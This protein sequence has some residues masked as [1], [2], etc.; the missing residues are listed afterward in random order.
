MI[1]EG[2]IVEEQDE[3][4]ST[5]TTTTMTRK[6]D[7][8]AEEGEEEEQEKGNTKTQRED[9]RAS[10]R[11]RSRDRDREEDGSRRSRSRRRDKDDDKRRHHSSSSSSKSRS[12]RREREAAK[13]EDKRERRREH[14]SRRRSNSRSRLSPHHRERERDRDKERGRRKEDRDRDREMEEE[15]FKERDRERGRRRNRE[16]EEP[17]E[18]RRKDR[19]EK[20]ANVP[21]T[22]VEEEEEEEQEEEYQRKVE[23]ELKQKAEE[24][25]LA[26]LQEERRRRRQAILSKYK[27]KEEEETK[28]QP[29]GKEKEETVGEEATLKATNETEKE[30]N[31]RIE[32][33][34]KFATAADMF[35]EAPLEPTTVGDAALAGKDSAMD[36]KPYVDDTWDDEEGY[37]SVRVGEILHKRY[38]VY[39]SHGKGVFSTVLQARD[40]TKPQ[41]HTGKEAKVAIKVIRN[42][43]VMYRSGMKEK[44]LLKKIT[45]ADPKNKKHCVR[46]LDSFV[47]RN[48]LC[49]VLEPMHLDLR[50]VIKMFGRKVGIA[51]HAVKIY[52]QQLFISL[53]HI[54]SLKILH[55]DLKPDN[56]V[57][58]K[59]GTVLKLCDFGSAS[60]ADEENAITPYLVSRFYR[61][62][63]IMLGLPYGY[64]IDVWS[65]GCCLFELFTGRILFPG[66]SNNE[67]LKLHMQ[68]K[69]MFPRKLLRK[70]QFWDQHFDTTF[71]FKQVEVD[72]HT[73]K[74]Y[75]KVVPILQ[76]ARNLKDELLATPHE[77]GTSHAV[78]QLADFLERCFE[79]NPQRRITPEEALLH[80]FLRP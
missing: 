26:K 40:I 18:E 46:L 42:N 56:I 75:V 48:H 10:K 22:I 74:E 62:P 65:A 54:K 14:S 70:S 36:I 29:N 19:G 38:R 78:E 13:E 50:K 63:E 17:R 33:D 21:A 55:A 39:A 3:Q 11:A 30:S 2:E 23:Q 79:L 44:E 49:L 68:L 61:A 8:K 45:D 9:T 16:G 32:E 77:K 41:R 35:S 66:K 1:E 53:K 7:R 37:Y 71:N 34:D 12:T 51:I 76:P 25:N 27:N 4:R 80:P 60:L 28:T 52:A 73:R 67:M 6:R 47:H 72:E 20:E 59:A 15:R 24:E 69:G 31:K 64:P 58:N 43:E 57:T 5:T